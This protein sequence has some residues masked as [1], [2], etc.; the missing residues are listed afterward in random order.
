MRW[1]RHRLLH[2]RPKFLQLV[3]RKHRRRRP[4]LLR[5]L[6]RP[7]AG[8]RQRRFHLQVQE[9]GMRP[10]QRLLRRQPLRLLP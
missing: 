1:H 2:R 5:L 9:L 6:K 7:R 3:R 4:Q 10:R 8:N